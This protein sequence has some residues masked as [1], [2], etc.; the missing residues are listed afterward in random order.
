MPRLATDDQ[1][2]LLD[3]LSQLVVE[4]VR[5][6]ASTRASFEARE[7]TLRE[8]FAADR[9]RLAA[10]S[11]AEREDL[12]SQYSNA[13]T[14]IVRDYETAIE[15]ALN[16][17]DHRF[18]E[19]T[20]WAEKAIEQGQTEAEE[21][22]ERLQAEFEE[23]VRD[24]QRGL[25]EFKDKIEEHRQDLRSLDTRAR[26]TLRK[27]YCLRKVRDLSTPP[28]I[29][30][31]TNPLE[32][33]VAALADARRTEQT[34]A[35]Q[36]LPKFLM[37]FVV[38]MIPVLAT[39]V[40]LLIVGLVRPTWA[41]APEQAIYVSII[42]A[43]VLGLMAVV[44]VIVRP[45]VV[46]HSKEAY[47]TLLH[48]IANADLALDTATK[49]RAA[50]ADMKKIT[51][52]QQLGDQLRQAELDQ[53]QRLDQLT[54]QRESRLREAAETLQNQRKLAAETRDTRQ[55]A[56]NDQF[57]QRSQQLQAEQQSL[58][59]QLQQREQTETTTS[60]DMFERSWNRLATRWKTGLHDV[61][62]ALEEM[63][64]YC[65][66]HFPD[67]NATDWE[68]W[69]S[70]DDSL[71]AVQFGSYAF[72][73]N[74]IDG[75]VPQHD[76][77][78]PDQTDFQVPAVMSFT[79]R[80][81]LLLE[82]WGEGRPIA[83]RAM[84]NVMLRL[85]TSLPAGKVRFTIVDPVG[86]GQNFSAFMHLAD[87]DEKLVTHRIWTDPNHIHQRLNDLTEHMEDVIQTYLRNEF[88]TI[89]EYNRHAGEVAEPFHVLV[90]ANFPAGFSDEAV[91][92]LLSI[93]S[94][95]ARCGVYTLISTDSKLDWPR[96]FN[97]ADLEAH[98]ATVQWNGTRFSWRD[99]NLKDLPLTLDDPPG[100]ER[101]TQIIRTIGHIAKDAIRVQVPFATVA[102][103]PDQWWSCDSRDGIEIPL[104]RAGASKLQFLRLGKG[105]SQHVLISGKTGS[106][107]STLLHAMI[108]NTAIHYSPDEV[109]FY[110]IDFKKGVEFKPY[111]ARHLPH[112][113]V[114][115]IESEREF[116]MSVL[117]RLDQE[118]R[119][120][121][122]L[123]R[124]A[125]VQDIKNFRD[126]NP[127]VRMPRL[128]LIIDEFQEFFTHDDKLAQDAALLL[129]RLVRQ[130]RAFGIHVLLGSQTLAGA[131]SL[132]R[133]TLGQMAVRIALQ[134]SE[135]DSHLILSEDNT[136]ARLLGR[137]GE[138]IYNDA[139][140][141]FEGNHPFQVVWLSA[142]EQEDYLAQLSIRSHE[143]QIAAPPAIVFE[144]N[145]PADPAENVLLRRLVSD[146]E[147][148]EM[149][150]APRAWLGSAVAIKDPTAAVFR[151][152][153]GANLL[154]VGQQEDMSLGMLAVSVVSLG[155]AFRSRNGAG[156]RF[157]V[158][159]GT[160]PDAP[161]AGWWTR[162]AEKLP[163]QIQIASPAEASKIVGELASDVT[164]R[165]EG[166]NEGESPVF[167]VVYNLAR[168][169][170]L[171]RS[172]DDLGFSS[173]DDGK[174]ASPS[175]Q[176]LDILRDGPGVGVHSLIWC[177]T[178]NTATRWFDRAALREL[179]QRVLFQMSANDS[180][181]LIDSPAASRLGQHRAML[182]S[183]ELGQQEKFRPY[184]M[185]SVDWL[186]WFAKQFAG[187]VTNA[188]LL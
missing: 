165:L 81:A 92:R 18:R 27:R 171:R 173:F 73:L 21:Q 66:D 91:Q 79:D 2:L 10:T 140:G 155:A 89:D 147:P 90:V 33:Y 161:E 163:L 156:A 67:W 8:Q 59:E 40:G 123:F 187:R 61:R 7:A 15:T 110:L 60:R 148:P 146:G 104:G 97:L 53:R 119:V 77:L 98:A 62:A 134:C 129:D 172:D 102:A 142:S 70:P 38:L 3:Q 1:R 23:S 106:G 31:A 50:D 44:Y 158:L 114:V 39:T 63:W 138:A 13:L 25:V 6:E 88:Q 188:S 95:G 125:G 151:R 100:D 183:E 34:L 56:I 117:E 113:R 24:L 154:A 107:K 47:L 132:A 112:A 5:S 83:S 120:R 122:D 80:P 86:L 82:A 42:G 105:T 135:A 181:N 69:R 84:Q 36:K 74:L 124:Q 160:R 30:D 177:D 75:G 118:L 43:V 68:T 4:R 9:Q 46:A 16:E 157:V 85:L 131:Y 19:V 87:F 29:C 49:L 150:L 22:V 58:V 168:F 111:A 127:A 64:S 162:F 128:L 35:S 186:E 176:L 71:S 169:R 99:E 51:R 137:P 144:G 126:E 136:A 55:K 103:K 76:D 141:L 65:R 178:Y 121:G 185:P 167:L 159:D 179:D 108:T 78:R 32:A 109:E 20:S 145:V 94:S 164:R 133:S 54:T 174:P 143:G 175:K 45:I 180:S 37:T 184:G 28:G 52:Q 96:N 14:R 153:S 170:E 26:R 12:Q 17:H 130:G 115:A 41:S 11:L 166:G 101:F 72:S 116:G 57:S 149:N 48:D 182:Y 93:V 139:N 152:Q